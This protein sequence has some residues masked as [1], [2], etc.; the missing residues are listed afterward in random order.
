MHNHKHRKHRHMEYASHAR[1][2]NDATTYKTTHSTEFTYQQNTP[3][4]FNYNIECYTLTNRHNNTSI[5]IIY[6]I[7]D[8]LNIDLISNPIQRNRTAE[9]IIQTNLIS[10]CSLTWNNVY[11]GIMTANITG[12]QHYMKIITTTD[13]IYQ[14]TITCTT[15]ITGISSTRNYNITV[16]TTL[17]PPP[18][19]C[20][21]TVGGIECDKEPPTISIT[22]ESTT[23]Q[24]IIKANITCTDD[25]GCTT[26][27][28]YSYTNRTDC[29]QETYNRRESYN[30]L[31]T[32]NNTGLLCIKALDQAGK[33]GYEYRF[34]NVYINLN[35]TLNITPITNN[36]TIYINPNTLTTNTNPF[37]LAV[38]TNIDA[39]CKYSKTPPN[40]QT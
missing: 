20:N 13:R 26:T 14:T 24:D 6:T 18:I 2:P 4:T 12:R 35:N 19:I 27:F 15:P 33:I 29:T 7:I 5:T 31:L 17:P 21:E 9:I 30:N 38:S 16:N 36:N 39:T 40:S 34:I 28:N 8:T 23:F 10:N 25:I 3:E 11:R 32:I 37:N 1:K 22:L